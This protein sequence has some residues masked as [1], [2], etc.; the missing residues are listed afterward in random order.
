MA[1]LHLSQEQQSACISFKDAVL[2]L[3]TFAPQCLRKL[4]DFLCIIET[5]KSAPTISKWF[6]RYVL[7]GFDLILYTDTFCELA[8]KVLC[9]QIMTVFEG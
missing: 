1:A 3:V 8:Q 9:D 7:N 2:L 6:Q 5:R 4:L